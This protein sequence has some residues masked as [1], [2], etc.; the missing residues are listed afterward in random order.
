[1]FMLGTVGC[2]VLDFAVFSHERKVYLDDSVAVL[3]DF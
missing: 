1:M 3:V 2:D